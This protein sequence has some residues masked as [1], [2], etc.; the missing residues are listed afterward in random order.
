MN[1]TISTFGL[2]MLVDYFIFVYTNEKKL[3]SKW[4]TVTAIKRNWK[5][6]FTLAV[7]FIPALITPLW[8]LYHYHKIT[9]QI[10]M[11]QYDIFWLKRFVAYLLD[12]NFG[13]LPYFPVLLILFSITILMGILKKERKVIILALSF[14]IT[15]FLYSAMYH[16][17][18]GM[19]A[20]ARYNSWS[21]PF[22]VIT[23]VSMLD[24]IFKNYKMRQIVVLLMLFSAGA[25]ITLTGIVMNYNDGSYI[26]F[27]SIAKLL[28][29]KTPSL[30][31][32]Y[33]FTFVSRNQHYDGGYDFD[34]DVPFVYYSDDGYARK[35][36]I[37]PNCDDPASFLD[38]ALYGVEK[39]MRWLLEK[40]KK[41]KANH[42]LDWR[43]LNISAKTLTGVY[44]TYDRYIYKESKDYPAYI[45]GENIE[46][47]NNKSIYQTEGWSYPETSGTWTDG[48]MAFLIVSV[49]SGNDLF[50]HLKIVGV[51]NNNPV[52]V[53]VN[54]T[55]VGN[56]EFTIGDNVIKIPKEIRS[57]ELIRIQFVFKNHKSPKEM[58]LS[59]DIRK[60]GMKINSFYID[61][62]QSD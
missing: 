21:F 54:D 13:F 6:T 60:L 19:T 53:Y 28:M 17:N 50:L 9:P 26:Y 61:T 29:D 12:L 47:V 37:P 49:E 45:L 16:I 55:W 32:P 34:A 4:N 1:I 7:C 20:M 3:S 27:T 36:L 10:S 18:C 46:L 42:P 57:D 35:I 22:L 33:P 48:K 40:A 52:D 8:N 31:N 39:D 24:K 59:G 15:V 43:Y 2:V 38:F 5:E 58:G 30:Y 62:Q 11:A 14:I 41:I 25:T 44:D 56:F 51:F 23:V